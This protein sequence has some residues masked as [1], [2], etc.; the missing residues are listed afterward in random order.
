MYSAKVYY[1]LE[2][3]IAFFTIVDILSILPYYLELILLG[4]HVWST[5][6]LYQL[7]IFLVGRVAEVYRFEAIS[8]IQAFPLL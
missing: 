7:F 6:C 4:R 2:S 5:S 1:I 8:S 3:L